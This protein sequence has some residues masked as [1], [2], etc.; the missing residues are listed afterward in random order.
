MGQMGLCSKAPPS[1]R[2]GVIL[3]KKP[4]FAIVIGHLRMLPILGGSHPYT[5]I[6]PLF[7]KVKMNLCVTWFRSTKE[8]L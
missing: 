8:Y 3:T 4:W 5:S 7:Y 1:L 6:W 2:K